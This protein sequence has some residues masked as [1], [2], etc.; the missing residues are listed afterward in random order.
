LVVALAGRHLEKVAP[1]R[2]AVDPPQDPSGPSFRARTS[3][4][5]S[6]AVFRAHLLAPTLLALAAACATA[7]PKNEPGPLTKRASFDLN[8]PA[9]ELMATKL[10]DKTIGVRGCGKRTVYIEVCGVDPK[11]QRLLDYEETCRWLRQGEISQDGPR[12]E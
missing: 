9:R 3:E 7:P 11:K 8:C 4:L 5:G 1:H 12:P 10:D 2:P 6:D